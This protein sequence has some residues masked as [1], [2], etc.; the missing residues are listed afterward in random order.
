MSLASTYAS[1][2]PSRAADHRAPVSEDSCSADPAGP[3][4]DWV[5]G[6]AS[7]G[8]VMSGW[9]EYRTQGETALAAPGSI[10]FG[11]AGEH[12]NVRH[13][14]TLG[15]RRLV[16]SF[17]RDM[18]EDIARETGVNARFG[19]IALPP[20]QAATRMFAMMRACSH[21]NSEDTLYALAHAALTAEQSP[22]PERITARDRRRVQSAVQHIEAHF[23][24]PC[25][26]QSLADLAG[27]SRFHFV[28]MFGAIVGQSPNQYLINTR[29]RAAADWL[30]AT[31][32]PIAQIAFDVGF[33]DISHFY[34][35][36]RDAFAC[37]PRQWRLRA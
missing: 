29:M 8:F 34:A 27:L 3:A 18:L 13:V 24:E 9:F 37:T 5:Y 30:I 28:R 20:S 32:T 25:S 1:W 2:P 16:V 19:A 33:N 31:K 15:N 36:F 10:V 23:D 14:D 12:F 17:K 11:N 21:N 22:S 4:A 35:C 26:L 7:I 6:D